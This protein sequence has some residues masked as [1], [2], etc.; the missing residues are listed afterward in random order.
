MEKTSRLR[1]K[2]NEEE[3]EEDSEDHEDDMVDEDLRSALVQLL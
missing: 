3:C 2:E 1:T